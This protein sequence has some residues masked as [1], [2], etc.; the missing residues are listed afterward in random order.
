M[1]LSAAKNSLTSP[2]R[3]EQWYLNRQFSRFD[4]DLLSTSERDT[5]EFAT[6]AKVDLSAGNHVSLLDSPRGNPD[7]RK[8]ASI[9]IPRALPSLF[10][11]LVSKTLSINSV[12]RA[13]YIWLPIND[14]FFYGIRMSLKSSKSQVKFG[15][16]HLQ[17]EQLLRLETVNLNLY[18]TQILYFIIVRIIRDRRIYFDGIETLT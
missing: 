3:E 10:D 12:I 4:S 15:L 13:I 14:V 11:L 17:L 6:F 5:Y 7:G 9:K 16:F 8:F 18:E 2:S 1:A